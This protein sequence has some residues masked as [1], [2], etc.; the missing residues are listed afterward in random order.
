MSGHSTCTSRTSVVALSTCAFAGAVFGFLFA[1]RLSIRGKDKKNSETQQQPQHNRRAGKHTRKRPLGRSG[2]KVTVLGQGGASLGD[3]YVKLD[4][5]AALETLKA[6]HDCGIGFF[7]TSPYYG[8]GLSEAR[9]GVGL[10]HLPRVSFVLQTKVGRF[11]VPDRAAENGVKAGW[12]GGYHMRIQFDY[13]AAALVRQYEDSLQRLGLG[14]IDSLVIHDL[15]PTPHIV[16]GKT[17]GVPEARAHL[18]VL[19]DVQFPLCF[20]FNTNLNIK[21]YREP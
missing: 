4:N 5:S 15:E 16:K 17:D 18:E 6:A 14:Y 19:I 3:L 10:H 9:F 7:D 12:I 1:R 21:F 13:S 20:G 11:L 2:L 8:V